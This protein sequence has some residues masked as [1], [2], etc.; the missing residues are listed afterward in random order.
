MA[1]DTPFLPN[2]GIDWHGDVGTVKYGPG[3]K[4]M[5]VMFYNK[6]VHQPGP[7]SAAGR[8][9]FK[10]E[11][12]VRIAPP[13]ERLN[14]VDRPANRQDAHR[15]PIQYQQF[16]AN[17]EQLPEGTPIEQLYPDKP[18]VAATLRAY[19]VHTIEMCAELSGNA[20][21]SIGMGAQG[22]VNDAQ[23]YIEISNK[24]VTATEFRKEIEDKDRLIERLTQ[25]VA[26]LQGQ[27]N[28]LLTSQQQAPTMESIQQLLAGMMVR[29]PVA[30][31]GGAD[32]Q[33]SMINANHKTAD[34]KQG[35]SIAKSP[36]VRQRKRS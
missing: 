3:D 7:S 5:V 23:R 26:M 31:A 12:Y 33:M 21:D 29:P 36:Q 10:D 19:N 11:V 34:L 16:K 13:G 6:P 27:V 9:I 22:Y 17:Q 20:I 4:A 8:Q 32:P 24:G 25:N 18:S 15:F 14:I 30:M 1:D 35:V 2:N 28:T